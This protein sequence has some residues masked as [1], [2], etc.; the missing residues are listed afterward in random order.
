MPIDPR[1]GH[2][3][4]IS[5]AI[6]PRV[7]IYTLHT[8]HMRSSRRGVQWRLITTN[9]QSPSLGYTG[10]RLQ[11]ATMRGGGATHLFGP[12][13]PAARLRVDWPARYLGL[14][15]HTARHG[16]EA[17]SEALSCSNCALNPDSPSGSEHTPLG[18]ARLGSAR[19]GSALSR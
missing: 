14:R 7:A 17:A 2:G 19:L 1:P 13:Q 4:F 15:T 16:T 10:A 3:R 5:P 8:F 12:R 18:S 11:W 6:R 9:Q